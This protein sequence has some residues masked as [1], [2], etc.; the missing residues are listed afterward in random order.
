MGYLSSRESAARPRQA[1]HK[2]WVAMPGCVQV[3]THWLDLRAILKC[4]LIGLVS[5]K[6]EME[7]AHPAKGAASPGPAPALAPKVRQISQLGV[8]ACASASVTSARIA[9]ALSQH[10]ARGETC[11][12]ESRNSQ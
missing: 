7:G 9:Q 5:N 6:S 10:E 8:H 1:L 3:A 12:Q 2:A 11:P 4:S